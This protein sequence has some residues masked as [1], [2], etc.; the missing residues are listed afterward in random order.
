MKG[1]DYQIE[2]YRLQTSLDYIDCVVDFAE[3]HNMCIYEV[4]DQL[5]ENI[6]QKLWFEARKRNLIRGEKITTSM[7]EFFDNK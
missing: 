1:I 3:K 7:E 6:K 2:R 5:H 4:A